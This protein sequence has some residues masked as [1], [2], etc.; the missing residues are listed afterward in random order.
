MNLLNPLNLFSKIPCDKLG[1]IVAGLFIY[2]VLH[3][4]TPI[5]G[6]AM[7]IIAAIGK[8]I[9]DAAH[10]DKHTPDFWDAIATIIGGLLAF[11]SGL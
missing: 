6:L 4:I 7:V 9:Y 11:I 1:H 8:E 2:A 3:F 10:K 5:F